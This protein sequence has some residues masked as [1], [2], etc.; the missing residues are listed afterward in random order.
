MV[1]IIAIAIALLAAPLAANAAQ[2]VPLKFAFP[3]PAGSFVNTKAI[4]PWIEDVEKASGGAL[5]IKLYP[6]PTLG[7]F[8]NVYERTQ[9][10]VADIAFGIFGPLGG[11]FRRASVSA[12]PFEA[13]TPS[14]ASLA[15]WRIYAN[16]TIAKEFPRI[17][18]LALFDFP[19]AHVH[20]TKPIRS[21]DD[22]KGLKLGASGRVISQVTASLGAAPVTMAPPE[23]Y[24]SVSRGLIDGVVIPWTAVET[25]KLYEV[26]NHHV[27][28]PLG[29]APAYVVM[30]ERAYSR[31][32]KAA[33]QA[34]D[35]YSG[36]ALTRRLGK[37]VDAVDRAMSERVAAMPGHSVTQV[38]ADQEQAWRERMKG[39]VEDWVKRTPDGAK[40]LAAYREEIRK[41]RSGQ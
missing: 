32:P 35:R 34:I 18:V 7:E 40:V 22:L 4:T 20:T 33:Q 37:E 9:N 38:P 5:G 16:G 21:L 41:I 6:G 11:Q 1:R 39:V 25:F 8:R 30:N 27:E 13:R 29:V 28:A 10:G 14:E 24:Q 2:P 36:E 3:A 19:H 12:L 31:L 15:F 17:K 26:M 23:V